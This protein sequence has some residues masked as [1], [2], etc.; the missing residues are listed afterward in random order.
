MIRSTPLSSRLLSVLALAAAVS[1][2][3][4]PADSSNF[5]P[6][7]RRIFA[8]DGVGNLVTFGSQNPDEARRVAISGLQAGET[9]AGI[10]FR[11]VDGRL[12]AV[13]SS[14]RLYTVDTLTA[15]ATAVGTTPFTP[16]LAGS[17][18]GFDFNPTVDRIRVH[19]NTN[20][21]LRL[22]PVTGALAFVDTALTYVAGD[23]GAGTTPRVSGTAYTNSVSGATATVLFGIDSNRDVLVLVGAPNGGRMT[24]VGSLGVNTTDD[25]GFDIAGPDASRE[26]YV[27]V[28]VGSRS[29]LHTINL[30]TGATTRIGTIGTSSPVR[31][32]AVAP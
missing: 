30:S 23:P 5:E 18:F 9:L 1:A 22:H 7:G 29:E 11:P 26:A 6:Q 17:A 27:T 3:D 19:G 4:N 28:T 8:V 14:S 13:G 32:I 21:N 10:D 16:A 2:C 12:Y 15:A 24:T 25:V 20:Q 31:G